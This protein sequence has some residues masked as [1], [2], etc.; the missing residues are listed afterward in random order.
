[1]FDTRGMRTIN[2]HPDPVHLLDEFNAKRTQSAVRPFVTAATDPVFM[3]VHQQHLPNTEPVPD[4]D[5]AEVS[6]KIVGALQGSVKWPACRH[7]GQQ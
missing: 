6:A 2:L 4:L 5:Q 1:M 3:V 7:R